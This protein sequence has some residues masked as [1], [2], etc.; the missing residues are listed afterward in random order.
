MRVLRKFTC[1]PSADRR[2]LV[3]AAL[4]MGLVGVALRLVSFKKLL[5]LT[6]EFSHTTSQGQNPLPPS[7]ERITWAIAAVSRRIPLFSRCLTQAIA[8]KIILARCGYPALM[9][10]GVSRNENGRLEAH[11]WVESQGAIVVGAPTADHFVP[12]PSIDG[13]D[14]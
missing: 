10:I 7:S 3:T 14:C 4:V 9:R 6:E 8:A 2:L 1:L 13:G 12:L 5:H 11:A